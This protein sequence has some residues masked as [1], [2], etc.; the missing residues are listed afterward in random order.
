MVSLPLP[1]DDIHLS[2]YIEQAIRP[3]LK[4]EPDLVSPYGYSSFEEPQQYY[5]KGVTVSYF[6]LPLFSCGLF[7][8]TLTFCSLVGDFRRYEDH[9]VGTFRAIG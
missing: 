2:K 7:L 6:L 1:V 9:T 8:S 5:W 4:I 3:S